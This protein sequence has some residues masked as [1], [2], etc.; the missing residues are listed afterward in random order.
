VKIRSAASTLFIFIF[1]YLIIF[2]LDTFYLDELNEINEGI[3]IINILSLIS[4][5]PVCFDLI[6]NICLNKKFEEEF[7]VLF[8]IRSKNISIS[9]NQRKF[10]SIR[11]KSTSI[12][13]R[14]KSNNDF[15]VKS[16]YETKVNRKISS[17]VLQDINTEK[18]VLKRRQSI[19]L[20]NLN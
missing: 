18:H 19:E 3:L 5:I 7:N 4:T 9:C 1:N 10:S 8:K 15:F 11:T 14:K 17:R 16:S 20:K 6:T 2:T 13:C 12:D